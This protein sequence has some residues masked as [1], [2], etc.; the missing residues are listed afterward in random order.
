MAMFLKELFWW[1]AFLLLAVLCPLL[2]A[3]A[4]LTTE[5]EWLGIVV[6]NNLGELRVIATVLLVLMLYTAFP[7]P[8]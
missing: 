1:A 2:W 7:K 8:R 3:M 5:P 6:T 4:Q